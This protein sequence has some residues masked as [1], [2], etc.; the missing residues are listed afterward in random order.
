MAISNGTWLNQ[1]LQDT[2]SSSEDCRLCAC[3]ASLGE[4]DDGMVLERAEELAVA[5]RAWEA[6]RLLQFFA[7]DTGTQPPNFC[8]FS[9]YIPRFPPT[10]I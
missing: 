1:I 8:H 4:L 7:D 9:G 2:G 10:S 6:V 5:S 3:A